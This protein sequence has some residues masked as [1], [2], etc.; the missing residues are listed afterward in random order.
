MLPRQPPVCLCGRI[1]HI[2]ID[3]N[4]R[5][6]YELFDLSNDPNELFNVADRPQYAVALSE[7]RYAEAT[8]LWYNGEAR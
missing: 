5:V 1:N 3:K 7:L 4:D 6:Y 2:H 8:L